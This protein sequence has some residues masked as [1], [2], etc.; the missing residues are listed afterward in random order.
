MNKA[1]TKIQGKLSSSQKSGRRI[2]FVR[3]KD[4]K[5]GEQKAGCCLSFSPCENPTI[6]TFWET[7]KLRHFVRQ[8][9]G[10][11]LGDNKILTFLKTKIWDIL[12]DN[13]IAKF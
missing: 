10:D 7:T 13:E 1:F 2:H 9:T 11:I 6:G 12:K 5:S 4:E 3:L 8:Q